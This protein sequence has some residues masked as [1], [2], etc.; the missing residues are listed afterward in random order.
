MIL[1]AR[2]EEA[3]TYAARLHR[4]QMRKGTDIPYVSHLLAVASIVLEYGGDEDEAIAALL[5][6]GPED[7]GGSRVLD[8]IRESFGPRVA[9][10]VEA[11]SDSMT[12]SPDD[13][14]G[15]RERK[16]RYIRHLRETTDQSVYLVSVADKLH[17]GRAI[18]SDVRSFG[19]SVWGRFKGGR[20]GTIWNYRALLGA[21]EARA[22]DDRVKRAVDELRLVVHDLKNA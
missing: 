2:F 9:S 1:S 20:E 16:E 22:H 13:K 19:P 7:Q 8:E 18:A 5:H 12:E 14:E 4:K 21:Y 6:D 17:N 15:W 11:C 3:L 10:I